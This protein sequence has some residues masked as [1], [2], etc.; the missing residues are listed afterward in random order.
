[1]RLY[2]DYPE[3]LIFEALFLMF[4]PVGLSE[5]GSGR[6]RRAMEEN[7]ACIYKESICHSLQN[8]NK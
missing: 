1:M 7:R 5:I 2:L 6:K 8:T 3:K 4:R